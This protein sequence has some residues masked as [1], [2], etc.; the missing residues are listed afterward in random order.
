MECEIDYPHG[1]FVEHI[2]TWRKQGAEVRIYVVLVIESPEIPLSRRRPFIIASIRCR[3]S[4]A[5]EMLLISGD[6]PTPSG[7]PLSRAEPA[8]RPLSR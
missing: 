6:P 1:R 3:C 2:I 5:D 4:D 8:C 7:T